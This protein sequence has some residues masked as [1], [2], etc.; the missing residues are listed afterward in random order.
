MRKIGFVIKLQDQK[1]LE[2]AKSLVESLRKADKNFE[3]YFEDVAA[4]QLSAKAKK[5]VHSSSGLKAVLKASELVVVIGGDGT[6]LRCTRYLLHASEWKHSKLVGINTGTLGFLTC[7]SSKEAL[8]EL[9]K[10]MLKQDQLI[11]ENRHCLKVD[12]IRNKKT[13]KSFHVLNDCVLS[14]GS[15]S[16]IFEFHIDLNGQLLSSY[17]ADGLI[18]SPPTGS[19][20][21]NL[22]A[23]GAIIQPGIPA[24]QL[25]PICPQYFS[26]KPIVLS[27]ENT[28][29]LRLGRHSTDVFLTLDGQTGLRMHDEDEVQISKSDKSLTFVVPKKNLATHYFDSLRQKLNWG[30]VSKLPT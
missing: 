14:K 3:F 8:R 2:L 5:Y 23:G 22:A 16:R 15:L 11:E 12:I 17:R 4:E 26:N 28:I 18:V 6:I 20:A 13:N 1:T 19:T 7:L 30:M 21:Y 25:T 24:M 29:G 10:L 27:Y 9:P